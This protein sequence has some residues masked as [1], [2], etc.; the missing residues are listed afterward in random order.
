MDLLVQRFPFPAADRVEKVADVGLLATVT[1][2]FLHYLARGVEGL[3]GGIRQEDPAVL[4]VDFRALAR[5]VQP[6]FRPEAHL[7][8]QHTPR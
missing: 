7:I 3:P 6:G 4:P 1:A 5:V 2:S 8:L